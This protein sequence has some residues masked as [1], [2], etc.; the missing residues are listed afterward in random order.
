MLALKMSN[1]FINIYPH[2]RR[3]KKKRWIRLISFLG[4]LIILYLI[5]KGVLTLVE[6][7]SKLIS[8]ISFPKSTQT[9]NPTPQI[10]KA[11]EEIVQ[12]SLE[13]ATGTYSV[14]IKNPAS[15]EDYYFLENRI[16]DAGSLYKLWVMAAVIQKIQNGE[17]KEDEVLTESIQSLNQS[18]DIDPDLAEQKDGTITLSVNQALNQMITISHNYASLLLSKKIGLPSVE[19]FLAENGFNQSNVGVDGNNPTTNA[20]D[21]ALF[22]EKLN[23]GELA[24]QQYTQEMLDL[25][26]R[27]E[28]NNKLPKYLPSDLQIAH[29]TGEI[30]WFTHDA[31]IIYTQKQNYIMV[32]LSESDSPKGAEDRIAQLSKAVYEYFNK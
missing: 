18:F 28:L 10:S 29:K 25:L 2:S 23:K 15:S 5:F 9:R 6:S 19:N 26:K 30:G 24:N 3:G 11:L 4:V 12:K 7:S 13:G 31:G 8:P 27:Q 16:Y 20:F 21:I 32:V 17:L 1:D 14:V 22:F